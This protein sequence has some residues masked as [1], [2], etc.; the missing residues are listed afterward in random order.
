[1]IKFIPE[2]DTIMSRKEEFRSCEIAF[3]EAFNSNAEVINKLKLYNKE[4]IIVYFKPRF[5]SDCPNFVI[6]KKDSGVVLVDCPDTEK[7]FSFIAENHENSHSNCK[8][9]YLTHPFVKL[10]KI[11]GNLLGLNIET[12][13]TNSKNRTETYKM[14]NP[15]VFFENKFYIDDYRSEIIKETSLF[16]FLDNQYFFK[17]SQVFTEKHFANFMEFLEP[18]IRH[19]D[20]LRNNVQ[21]DKI[22][23]NLAESESSFKKVKGFAGSG[24]TTIMLLRA[25]SAVKRTEGNVLIL[26]FNKTLVNFLRFRL[27]QFAGNV[28]IFNKIEINYYHAFFNSKANIVCKQKETDMF[29]DI[30]FFDHTSTKFEKY[31]AI[32]IDEIQDYKE[33][34]ISILQK[35]F[36]FEDGEFVVFADEKQTIYDRQKGDDKMPVIPKVKGRWNQLK[37]SYRLGVVDGIQTQLYDIFI[38]F[39]TEFM[40]KSYETDTRDLNNNE[41]VQNISTIE[42]HDTYSDLSGIIKFISEEIVNKSI[43]SVTAAILTE[44]NLSTCKIC[45]LLDKFEKNYI[46]TTLLVEEI[47]NIYNFRHNKNI[48]KNKLTDE[49]I[50]CVFKNLESTDFVAFKNLDNSKKLHFC[51]KPDCIMVST[52]HSF[53]GYEAE[54]VFVIIERDDIKPEVIYTAITRTSKNLYIFDISPSKRYKLFF[55]KYDTRNNYS[56]LEI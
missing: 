12:I 51:V 16:D 53:K 42:Y 20:L 45:E 23:E 37:K 28:D 9:N 8:Q 52:I 21:L 31:S 35:Y 48:F 33:A 36:L 7:E 2:Y 49:Q 30:S 40:N 19:S 10:K 47:R 56:A 15:L 26:C 13:S 29:E 24:K 5:Y 14:V 22:Q 3:I 55:E 32:F 34:W 18:K 25:I 43:L 44:S 4:P 11:K 39:Q 50:N 17:K 54:N 27:S 41:L 46:S 1:M 38:D 6:I